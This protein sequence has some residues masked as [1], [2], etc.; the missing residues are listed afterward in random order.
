MS[1][2][3]GPCFFVKN[4]SFLQNI[5]NSGIKYAIYRC[6]QFN[7][8][9]L[10]FLKFIAARIKQSHDVFY[11]TSSIFFFIYYNVTGIQFP[12]GIDIFTGIVFYIRQL[13][14][15]RPQ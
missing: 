5:K 10:K 12:E 4:K 13:Y 9:T 14:T 1:K 6:I 8:S 15:I 7:R 11:F 3:F 2:A